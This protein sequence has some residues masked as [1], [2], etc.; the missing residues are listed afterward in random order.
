MVS[1]K[2]TGRLPSFVNPFISGF[3]LYPNAFFNGIVGYSE[4]DGDGSLYH[5][6]KVE[7]VSNVKLENLIIRGGRA[8]GITPDNLG[9]GIYMESVMYSVLTN[10]IVLNNSAYSGGG[11]CVSE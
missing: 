11:I 3:P 9:G 4:L 5:V 10:I 1:E 7:G 6:V 2:P 8:N